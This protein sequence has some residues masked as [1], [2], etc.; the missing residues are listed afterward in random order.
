[1][2]R[3][4]IEKLRKESASYRTK[5]RELEPLAKKAQEAD[6]ASKTEMQR[7]QERAQVAET[8]AQ[9]LELAVLRTEI[10]ARHGLTPAQAKRLTGANE[11]ELDADAEAYAKEIGVNGSKPKTDLKQGARGGPP[12]PDAEAW[13]RRL[14]GRP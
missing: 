7:A 12:A 3:T 9:E 11:A 10:A 14:A 8:R 5:V 6:E 1:V 4:E 2:A 13:L